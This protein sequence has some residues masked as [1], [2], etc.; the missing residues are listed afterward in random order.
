MGRSFRL[1]TCQSRQD[2]SSPSSHRPTLI[3]FAARGPGLELGIRGG[4]G[5]AREKRYPSAGA[6]RAAAPGSVVR[7]R[8][9]QTAELDDPPCRLASGEIAGWRKP[10]SPICI[11]EGGS[12][13]VPP[14]AEPATLRA[15]GEV[16]RTFAC[17]SIVPIS[18]SARVPGQARSLFSRHSSTSIPRVSRDLAR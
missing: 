7:H 1:E 14:S 18:L 15:A 6:C 9:G 11:T 10:A 12:H 3:S 5:L 2:L 4:G 16:V 13:P 8:D 17:S